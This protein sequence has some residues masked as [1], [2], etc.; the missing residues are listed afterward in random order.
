METTD[1]ALGAFTSQG[2]WVVD[3]DAMPWR[4]GIDELR[5]AAH[6]TV[7]GL[8]DR[9]RVPGWHLA[10]VGSVLAAAVGPSLLRKVLR[11]PVSS[12]AQAR[13][14]RSA[15]E[16]LGPTYVK[17]GQIIA[18]ADGMLPADLVGEFKACRD[19]MQ[20]V[21]FEVARAV[22]ESELGR[23]LGDVFAHFDPTPI[24]AA[25]IA[26]VHGA[27]LLGGED[28]VV[29]VQ[30]P[31]ASVLVPKDLRAMAWLAPLVVRAAPQLALANLP[32]YLELFA[33]TIV[34]ELDFRLE[35]QNMLDI[36]AV[37]AATEQRAV[38]VPR[39]HPTLVTR[40]VLVMERLRGF[41]LD[42]DAEMRQAGIDP[43]AVFTAL[44]VSFFEGA[45]IYGVFHGDLHGGNMI[46]TPEGK[47]G[48][49]DFGI[50]GRFE[51]PARIALMKLVFGG[52]TQDLV[53]QIR[54]FRDLG[55]LPPDAD[56]EEI[57]VQL[58]LER[59]RDMKPGELTPEQMNE[60]MKELVNQLLARG[61]SLP[62]SLFL[63]MKGMI[64]LN[65]AISAL[66]ADVDI[67]ATIGTVFSYLGETHGDLFVDAFG[68]D[69][70]TI[71]VAAVFKEQLAA[72]TGVEVTDTLSFRELQELQRRQTE[73]LRQARR[74]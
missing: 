57:V 66:A 42:E 6:A 65:G 5:A 1:L 8:V 68:I 46:V 7:P 19:Q 71:D 23:P 16:R 20:P 18:S 48:I 29:K 30:R 54:A 12:V 69:L 27:R 2:P 25:S 50:T 11:R 53:D 31:R 15:F 41:R 70:R 52:M 32:A 43:S 62:K 34:E 64:Y 59:L 35:A 60:Q 58:D 36:A 61:A 38:I 3:P 17:L 39:P 44:L 47:A 22:V 67:L 26:Q 40:R 56:V 28:V 10:H 24:A 4:R 51:E 55:G 9:R 21:P 72:Q 73:E 33:E 74:G 37:L 63:Y 14:L 45:G 13:A 49:F